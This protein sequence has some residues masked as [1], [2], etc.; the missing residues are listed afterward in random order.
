MTH[1]LLKVKILKGR[2]RS[3]GM[4]SN[5]GP[6]K[7]GLVIVRY[8]CLKS[9]NKSCQMEVKVSGSSH[10]LCAVLSPMQKAIISLT[11]SPTKGRIRDLQYC[12]IICLAKA[13]KAAR[14]LN[15]LCLGSIHRDGI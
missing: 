8:S 3:G 1:S 6:A 7:Q 11:L 5:V 15:T 12:E 14:T 4:R 10:L 13:T 9:Y 2:V